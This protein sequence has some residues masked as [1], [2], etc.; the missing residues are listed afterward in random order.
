LSIY[1]RELNDFSA[2]I[3]ELPNRGAARLDI[4]DV[5]DRAL[6]D[7]L[8]WVPKGSYSRLIG[9]VADRVVP[10]S[11]RRAVYTAFAKRVG[12]NLD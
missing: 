5:K 10:R 8:R 4:T 11:A 7:L 9:F 6:V 12:A 1:S 2:S 3:A